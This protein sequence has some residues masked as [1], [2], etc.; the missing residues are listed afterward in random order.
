MKSLAN[1]FKKERYAT[2]YGPEETP[3]DIQKMNEK[4]KEQ[5]KETKQSLLSQMNVINY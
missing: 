2:N 3:E 4:Y 1:E 5:Q